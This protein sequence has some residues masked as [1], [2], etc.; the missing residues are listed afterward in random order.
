MTV[1]PAII[2]WHLRRKRNNR[3][4]EKDVSYNS[5]VFNVN[6]DIWRMVRVIYL[7]L[8]QIHT[9]RIELVDY[10]E[11]YIPKL[12][13][14]S[15]RW[16]PPKHGK[17][18][19]YNDG[20]STGNP[21]RILMTS[22]RNHDGDLVYVQGEEIN[23]TTYMEAEAVTIRETSYHC[24]LLGSHEL[25]LKLIHQEFGKFHGKLQQL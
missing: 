16:K 14:M 5:L 15:V 17:F 4:N 11:M 3:M 12:Y 18:K 21:G 25:I 20:A 19:C 2:M 9:N 24:M 7:K 8:R 1:V 6:T 13:Y 10:L 22:I 23:E